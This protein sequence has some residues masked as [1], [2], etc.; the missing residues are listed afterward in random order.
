MKVSILF[1]IVEICMCRMVRAVIICH[2][3]QSFLN[4]LIYLL[5]H[6]EQLLQILSLGA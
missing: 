3:Y 2:K 1:H 6:L 5:E 4:P